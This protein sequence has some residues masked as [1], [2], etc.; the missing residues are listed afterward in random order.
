MAADQ[1]PTS[2]AVLVEDVKA[3]V[4]P[5]DMAWMQ[6]A[7]PGKPQEKLRQWLAKLSDEEICSQEELAKLAATPEWQYVEL[8]AA[9]K[10]AL[11]EACAKSTG[12]C[13]GTP[14]AGMTSTAP[15]PKPD[16][17]AKFPPMG[18][19]PAAVAMSSQG[20]QP[21]MMV[22]PQPMVQQSSS[23][24]PAAGYQQTAAWAS[25]GPSG[26][27]AGMSSMLPYYDQTQ[28]TG[29]GY[30][31]Q[32]CQTFT[33]QPLAGTGKHL[34]LVVGETGSGKST[35]LN[36]VANYHRGGQFPHDVKVMIPSGF[37]AVTETDAAEQVSEANV[38]DQSLS[39]TTKSSRYTFAGNHTFCFIDT[40]GF[41]DTGGLDK[42]EANL[43]TVLQAAEDAGELHGVIL[44][45]N[46]RAPRFTD[47]LRYVLTKLRCNLP[48]VVMN[49]F[50][51]VM[52][53]C[54]ELTFTF[55]CQK[56]DEFRPRRIFYMD[57]TFFHRDP[58]K[59]SAGAVEEAQREWV[60]S[61]RTLAE[62]EQLL[63]GL[64]GMSTGDFKVLREKRFEIKQ[65]LHSSRAEFERLQQLYDSL[66]AYK[67]AASSHTKSAQSF[68]QYTA[69]KTIK[70]PVESTGQLTTT[71]SRCSHS[72]HVNC[73]LSEV[74]T[75][76]T[77]HF[78]GC[79]AMSGDN[80]TACPGK[81]HHT[82]HYH[83]KKSIRYEEKTI[84]EVLQD[85]KSKYDASIS[86]Q[87][88]A[89]ANVSTV[90]GSI[91]VARQSLSAAT[92]K[93]V[94]NM[95]QIKKVASHFN[96]TNEMHNELAIMRQ[97]GQALTTPTART[98]HEKMLKTV[99]VQLQTLTA[100]KP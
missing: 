98:E 5:I 69:T 44:V 38:G 62:M 33:R 46:G 94:A 18:P 78:S 1:V 77:N 39:Q 47:H 89:S 95:Q 8:P 35:F 92:Q 19:G 52:T 66:E 59:L 25:S 42:D 7:L 9:V 100:E 36:M 17:D 16:A 12:P 64:H 20:M 61:F 86:Q 76:G 67:A 37:F 27:N 70:V 97:K 34:F 85:V 2:A 60:R 71:C 63:I 50:V 31:P 93:I 48:D 99:E 72:C 73:G 10:A 14:A 82:Q 11:R 41:G 58:T 84:T 49:N 32:F 28:R 29:R 90:E 87:N 79:A 75:T 56:L 80:C 23:A 21:Q 43:Q 45:V 15:I 51:V 68:A 53:N 40:P 57:N 22:Q 81:C 26:F 55:P 6:R 96:L 4:H 13:Q 24:W 3:T 83:S 91:Q 54:S 65:T 88:A 30:G 74:T